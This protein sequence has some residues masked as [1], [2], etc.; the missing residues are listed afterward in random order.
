[1]CGLASAH[2][3]LASLER[4]DDLVYRPCIAVARKH[5][6]GLFYNRNPERELT[7]KWNRDVFLVFISTYTVSCLLRSRIFKNAN[8]AIEF[9]LRIATASPVEAWRDTVDSKR[10]ITS[11]LRIYVHTWIRACTR[12][13]FRASRSRDRIYIPCVICSIFKRHSSA[14]M[15]VYRAY[16]QRNICLHGREGVQEC[17]HRATQYNKAHNVLLH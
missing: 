12:E 2:T 7:R 3:F 15:C 4:F 9:E 16:V 1:M 11:V 13:K 14:Y 8:K 17:N 6:A 10:D 5:F